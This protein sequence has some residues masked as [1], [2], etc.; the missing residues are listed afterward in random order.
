V[1]DKCR[2]YEAGSEA[3]GISM[4]GKVE[5]VILEGRPAELFGVLAPV[6]IP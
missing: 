6:S 4:R 2:I 1:R 3:T 5:Q